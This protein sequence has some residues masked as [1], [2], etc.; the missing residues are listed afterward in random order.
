MKLNPEQRAALVL[1]T[2]D[3][4]SHAEAAKALGCAEATVSWR[5][6]AARRTLKRLLENLDRREVG[7]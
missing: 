6:F 1:T 5:L 4:L 7:I 2:Y 3:G